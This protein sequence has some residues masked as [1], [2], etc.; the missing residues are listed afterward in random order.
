VTVERGIPFCSFGAETDGGEAAAGSSITI[1]TGI[2]ATEA[3]S[4]RCSKNPTGVAARIILHSVDSLKR[5]RKR[6]R[7]SERNRF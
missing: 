7:T 1:S 4:V 6:R 2:A 3:G 5:R